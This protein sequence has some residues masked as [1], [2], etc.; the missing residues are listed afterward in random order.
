MKPE[1]RSPF[2][3]LLFLLSVATA[4]G[5]DSLGWRGDGSGKYPDAR[6]VLQWSRTSKAVK[7]LR[8]QATRP[9]GESKGKPMPDGVIREWLVLGPLPMKIEDTDKMYGF[10]SSYSGETTDPLG[11][12][13]ETDL[14]PTVGD[15]GADKTW[16]LHAPGSSTVNFRDLYRDIPLDDMQSGRDYA[17]YAHAYVHAG[18]GGTYAVNMNNRGAIR[19]WVNGKLAS[20]I[21]NPD[22]NRTRQLAFDKGWNRILIRVQPTRRMFSKNRN[23]W[24]RNSWYASVC[25]Y[26]I[27]G[28]TYETS[29][30]LW[31][32][33]LPN[34]YGFGSPIL[35][36]NRLFLQSGHGD[37]F[38]VD[39]ES[40]RILWL[41]SNIYHDFATDEERRAHPEVFK[42]VAPLAA[43]LKEINDSFALGRGPRL[44]KVKRGHRTAYGHREKEDLEKRICDLMR[45]VDREKYSLPKNQKQDED[46]GYGGFNPVSDGKHVFAWFATGVTVC[47]DLDGNLVWRKLDNRGGATGHHGYFWGVSYHDGKLLTFMREFLCR[48]ASD[49]R[50]LWQAENP[51]GHGHGQF[52]AAEIAG[53]PVAIAGGGGVLRMSDGA[54]LY[55]GP[56]NCFEIPTPV[57]DGK[58]CYVLMYQYLRQ[59]GNPA[60]TGP[61]FY[62]IAL[63]EAVTAPLDV[64]VRELDVDLTTF[65]ADYVYN[66][67]SSPIVHEGLAY[68]LNNAGV[69]TVVDVE[70][71]EIVYQKF[72]D[73]D[74]STGW[75]EG[76]G[77]GIGISPVLAG[78]HLFV[79]GSTGSCLVLKPGRTYQ[80]VAKNKIEHTLRRAGNNLNERFVACPV[81]DADRAYIRGEANL[82]CVGKNDESLVER[83]EPV[84]EVDWKSYAA[85]DMVRFR[86]VT[87]GEDGSITFNNAQSRIVIPRTIPGEGH[88]SLDILLPEMPAGPATIMSNALENGLPTWYLEVLDDGSLRLSIFCGGWL[89]VTNPARMQPGKWHKLQ[90]GWGEGGSWLALDDQR[91]EDEDLAVPDR[92]SGGAFGMGNVYTRGPGAPVGMKVRLPGLTFEGEDGKGSAGTTRP[93]DGGDSAGGSETS[94]SAT[95]DPQA[96]VA[97]RT[98]GFRGSGSGVYP[99]ARIPL[100]WSA[101]TKPRWKVEIGDGYGSAV[102]SGRHAFVT[103]EPD[104]LY[105]VDSKDGKVL[106]ARTNGFDQLPAADSSK[107]RKQASDCGY[108]T[109][110]PYT[111]GRHVWVV[112]GTGVVAC[113]DMAGERRWIRYIDHKQVNEYGRSASPVMADGKLIVTVTHL[114][115][116]DPGTGRILWEQPNAQEAYGTPAVTRI[117]K[118]DVLVTPTGY[119]VAADDGRVVASRMGTALNTSPVVHNGVAYFCDTETSAWKLPRSPEDKPEELWVAEIAGEVFA[120]PVLHEGILYCVDNDG[121]LYAINAADGKVLYEEDLLGG[122][123]PMDITDLYPSLVLANGRLLVTNCAGQ[124][125][126]IKPGPEFALLRINE[127]R[128][129][130]G[131]TPAIDTGNLLVRAGSELYL[132]AEP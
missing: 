37:L 2:F 57:L 116:L 106:W 51:S 56:R 38:C 13:T 62:R 23:M 46:L 66:F 69:L 130:S 24:P 68:L 11:L 79:F 81:F 10:G 20:S 91:V 114:V 75:G 1:M 119:V 44:E 64:K 42:E 52:V 83:A 98:C 80:Q 61:N 43:R 4:S 33:E 67:M 50:L 12:E 104:K 117:G 103:A 105:C 16:T 15:K 82:Y 17:A 6:P 115:A 65:P 87:G 22:L 26:G 85:D 72:L 3:I 121:Y 29:N 128:P 40:G 7:E 25:F 93:A 89:R 126:I 109:P 110:T 88:I 39:A 28:S 111:D 112:Y 27:P 31:A 54:L 34:G 94:S 35:V 58:T 127:R 36:G 124:T 14:Q 74:Q 131:S 92:S 113:Y 84:A 96:A 9:D 118:L 90:L 95:G 60:R 123:T 55:P 76:A 97:L 99:D 48:D 53:E 108:A 100:E 107:G 32:T 47:Y 120:S 63:P 101:D 30:L 70:R 86:D 132:F 49:G 59:A 41:R 21:E 102:I 77:R 122:D 78:E 19:L 125:A 8:F 45:E 5:A 129:G 18:E 73:L 71:M